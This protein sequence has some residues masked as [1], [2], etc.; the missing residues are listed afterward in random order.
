MI[1]YVRISWEDTKQ[2]TVGILVAAFYGTRNVTGRTTVWVW[3]LKL[4]G[5]TSKNSIDLGSQSNRILC[6]RQKWIA[7]NKKWRHYI[8]WWRKNS[9]RIIVKS[10]S[11]AMKVTE[12]VT[13]MPWWNLHGC[14]L[15][16]VISTDLMSGVPSVK[17]INLHTTHSLGVKP[18][19]LL[20]IE[21]DIHV[22]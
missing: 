19:W 18:N 17:R 14:T 5:Y 7:E 20:R 2:T 16:G 6:Y 1:T 22:S 13:F 15:Q 9:P 8:K 10:N 12:T 3:H 21:L 4:D 11:P